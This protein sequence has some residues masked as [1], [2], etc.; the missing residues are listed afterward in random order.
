L[1]LN[2]SSTT[3][4]PISAAQFCKY[5]SCITPQLYLSDY[6]I[7]QDE[8]KLEE[9]GITHVVSLLSSG[10]PRLPNFIPASQ[11][12]YIDIGDNE[13]SDILKHLNMTTSFINAAVNEDPEQ[14]VLVRHFRIL[15]DH[16]STG[17]HCRCIVDWE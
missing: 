16:N 1:G 9:L 14:K 5:A 11:K 13:D 2:L 10:A 17:V 12:L 15:D 6:S 7:I 4:S 3:I 8:A